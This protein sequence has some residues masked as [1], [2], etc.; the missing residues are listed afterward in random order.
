MRGVAVASVKCSVGDMFEVGGF[1]P[2]REKSRGV[3]V[4]Y[5]FS[6]RRRLL[7]ALH[8]L[9]PLF[10]RRGWG[11]IVVDKYSADLPTQVTIVV[12]VE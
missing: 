12:V 9:V 3:S 4:C 6:V 2:R 10:W 8:S 11:A 1:I 7:D 5:Y